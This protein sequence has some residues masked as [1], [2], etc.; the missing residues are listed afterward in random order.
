MW[1]LAKGT[2]TAECVITT[3]PLGWELRVTL[4][5]EL[6][7]SQ[8]CKTETGTLDTSDGWRRDWR[9]KGWTA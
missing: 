2:R 6:V 8:V 5:G 7:R 9:A 4:D 3:H 1:T